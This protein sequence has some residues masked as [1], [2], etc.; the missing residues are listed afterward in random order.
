MKIPIVNEQDEIIGYKK[1]AE[2]TRE[3]IRRIAGLHIFNEKREVL[4]AL[5][6]PSKKIDP[7]TWGPSV[8]GTVDEGYDYDTT[9]MKEAE[10]EVGLKNIE[11]IFY[12]KMF[13]E[14]HN[15]RRFT[16][17]YY[18]IINSKEK[19]ILQEDEVSEVRW[20]SVDDLEDWWTKK[21]E[22]FVPSFQ[23]SMDAIKDIYLIN[24]K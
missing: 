14:T 22:D 18:V 7:N 13:Y 2:T 8:V 23:R 5:R 9:I 12:T 6:H 19:F 11:P 16:G 17:V 10:E 3:D 1:R 20:V 15:A 24:K 21:P 4:V